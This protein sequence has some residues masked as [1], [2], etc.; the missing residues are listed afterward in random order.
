LGILP[1]KKNHFLIYSF[2]EQIFPPPLLP[3]KKEFVTEYSVLKIIF[4]ATKEYYW[5][6]QKKIPCKVYKGV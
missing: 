2:L 3:P 6:Q 4:T 1:K 5:R